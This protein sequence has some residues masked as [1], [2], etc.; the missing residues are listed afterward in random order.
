[1]GGVDFPLWLGI[2]SYGGLACSLLTTGALAAYAL[3]RR[4]GT[5]RQLARATLLCLSASL[6]SLAPLWWQGVRFDVYGPLL[7]MREILVVLVWSMAFGWCVPLGAAVRY[8]AR[9]KEMPAGHGF[10]LRLR[11]VPGLH[12]AALDD[13][14]RR[15]EPLG[16]NRAW[17]QL[18]P[19]DGELAERS[20]R[21][22][23]KL[24]LLGREVDNDVIVADERASRHHAEIH[25]DHG[26]PQLLDRGSMNGTLVNG[27][28]VRGA[29][30]LRSE[31]TIQIGE[32][33]YRFELFESGATPE[34]AAGDETS[35]A[36][37]KMVGVSSGGPVSNGSSP[38]RVVLAG[39]NRGFEFSRWELCDG[40]SVIGRDAECQICLNDPSV[41]RRH[42]QIVRQVSGFF[43]TDLQS[44]NGTAVNGEL[45]AAPAML[46]SG[47]VLR[48]GE[49]TLRC[50]TVAEAGQAY[51]VN[52]SAPTAILAENS[53]SVPPA[54]APTAPPRRRDGRLTGLLQAISA[55]PATK[56]RSSP[57][58]APPRL[59]GGQPPTGD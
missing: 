26:H 2:G 5:P 50:D 18:V 42:A 22:T 45:L 54:S 59:H 1:M 20:L 8:V 49:V 37:R 33:R 25:W 56:R 38:L 36:T 48:V 27:Q 4:R 34:M 44:S 6:L 41:S 28:T 35:E 14:G 57:R 43:L 47:D 13:P 17:G 3:G 23:H 11:A 58:L 24:T 21:L 53:R 52:P 12:I 40:I 16:E 55:Q 7:D 10:S 15:I 30:P 51:V 46:R 32:R 39:V 29:V 19:L 9:A 31:D